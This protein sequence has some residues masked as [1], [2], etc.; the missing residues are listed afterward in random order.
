MSAT[1][2]K[3]AYSYELRYIALDSNRVP[4][5]EWKTQ[6]M[7]SARSA[8]AVSGLTPG[9]IYAFE[10]HALGKLGYTDWSDPAHFM[11]T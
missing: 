5:G 2:V 9:T 7:G 8:V 10:V 4:V 3:G 1:P 11:C 6:A